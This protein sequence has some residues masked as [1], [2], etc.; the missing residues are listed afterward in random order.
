MSINS[1][2]NRII[3]QL[4]SYQNISYLH[5]TLNGKVSKPDILEYI[6]KH[7]AT[8]FLNRAEFSINPATTFWEMVR[9]C[10][11]V[12]LIILNNRIH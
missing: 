9:G 1:I 4:I 10:N 12:I 7:F 8:D 11:R 5:T 6:W 3:N 2:E